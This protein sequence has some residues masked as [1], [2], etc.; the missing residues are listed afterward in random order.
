MERGG[1]LTASVEV[2]NASEVDGEEVVQLYIHDLF[3]SRM[4]PIKELK[5]YKKV[6][7]KAGET[8][9][10]D[11]DI[12]ESMLKFWDENMDYV[13]ENGEFDVFVGGCSCTKNK[14]RL[15]LQ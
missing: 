7:I 2:T 12:D 15:V 4:R 1:T 9:R 3:A 8:V 13:A 14:A 6:L 5:A 10:V 11:F